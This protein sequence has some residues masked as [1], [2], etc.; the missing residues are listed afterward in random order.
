M[1]RNRSIKRNEIKA[2]ADEPDKPVKHSKAFL[3][4]FLDISETDLTFTKKDLR[5]EV[6]TLILA[7]SKNISFQKYS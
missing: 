5:D 1:I 4:H 7:V 6:T 3:D 2:D